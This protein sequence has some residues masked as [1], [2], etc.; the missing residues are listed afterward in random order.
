MSR[1][2]KNRVCK[3]CKYYEKVVWNKHLQWRCTY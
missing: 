3:N 2:K 1:K